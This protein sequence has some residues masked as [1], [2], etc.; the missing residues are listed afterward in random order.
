[1]RALIGQEVGRRS[2]A[3]T[4][5]PRHLYSS[6]RAAAS[7]MVLGYR[8]LGCRSLAALG[9]ACA[10]HGLGRSAGAGQGWGRADSGRGGRSG[11]SPEPPGPRV[12]ARVTA[13]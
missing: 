2:E 13:V 8:P 4:D 5:W 3:V 7:V 12:L 6:P 10:R 9:A 1:M 11:T